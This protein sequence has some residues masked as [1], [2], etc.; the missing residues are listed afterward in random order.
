M[1]RI[2]LKNTRFWLFAAL[3][4]AAPLSKYP[5]I[6]TPLFNF[7]S[8]R[9]GLYPVL[10]LL[11]VLSCLPGTLRALPKLYQQS[12]TS[13]ASISILVFVSLLGLTTAI[14]K[15]R[16]ILLVF[17]VLLLLGLLMTAWWYVA[18]ELAV[19]QYKK[20]IRLMLIAG[21][22][23]GIISMLQF[24]FA[25]FG[26]ETFGLLCKSCNSQVF[27]FPRINGFAAEPQFHANA[28][29]IYFFVGIGVFYTSR[30]RLALSSAVL[31][32]MGIGLTFSRGAFLAVGLGTI[33]FFVLLRMQKQVRIK[34]IIKHVAGLVI[35][36]FVVAALLIAAA[37][38]RYRGTPD[39]AYKTFRSMVQQASLG[40]IKLPE[41]DA[42][43]KDTGI[44]W[45][46]FMFPK[47][48]HVYGKRVAV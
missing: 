15:A 42:Q 13:M 5:S 4:V 28:L 45:G 27:G 20:L 11:F 34:T 48:F 29:M 19:A 17:S 3:L 6:A 12:R 36:I 2:H 18:Q 1:A 31:A 37:S 39:I 32:L 40:I 8:F 23:Y 9:I 16:S 46:V 43:T 41:S 7:T 26:H 10:S 25:G 47:S 35:A 33:L 21:C 14:Y 24:V 30:S 22:L 44:D 38:F